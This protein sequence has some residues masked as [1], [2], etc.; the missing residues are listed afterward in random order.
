LAILKEEEEVRKMNE[1]EVEVKQQEEKREN[2][3]M[4][5]H[6]WGGH[7]RTGTVISILLGIIYDLH[8]EVALSAHSFSSSYPYLPPS[9]PSPPS[10]PLLLPSPFPQ[11]CATITTRR[12][13]H[14]RA[15]ALKLQSNSIKSAAY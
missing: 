8:P 3:L 6:C 9:P 11:N 7:G 12:E 15:E 10:P 5:I 14:G 1:K 4:Y 13:S 2:G